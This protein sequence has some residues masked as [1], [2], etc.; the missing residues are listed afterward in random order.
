ME[1][2]GGFQT[3][4]FPKASKGVTWVKMTV[5]SVHNLKNPKQFGLRALRLFTSSVPVAKPP[6]EQ[7]GIKSDIIKAERLIVRIFIPTNFC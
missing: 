2:N 5:E 4:T 3:V 1:N 6:G 7:K